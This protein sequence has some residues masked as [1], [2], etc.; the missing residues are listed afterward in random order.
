MPFAAPRGAWAAATVP[1]LLHRVAG[2]SSARGTKQGLV[3]R[4]PGATKAAGCYQTVTGLGWRWF[5]SL[6]S[7]VTR[8]QPCSTAVA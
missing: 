7:L 1:A 8:R 2:S 5:L 3:A 4:N 6:R